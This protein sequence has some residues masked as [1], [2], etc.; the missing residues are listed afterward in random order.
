MRTADANHP[1]RPP[2]S[3]RNWVAETLVVLGI[4]A[5]GLFVLAL[6][7]HVDLFAQPQQAGVALPYDLTR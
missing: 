1:I 3:Q 7:G 6:E 4:V 5:F 2:R